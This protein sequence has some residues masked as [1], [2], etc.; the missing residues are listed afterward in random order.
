MER[1]SFSD[2]S[3]A[4]LMNHAFV[5]IKVDREERP[6]VDGIYMKAVQALTGQGGW[7]LTAFLTPEGKPFFGGTYF[8][9]QPRH[10]M[11]AFSQVL[12]AVVEA[13]RNRRED[14]LRNAGHLLA[15]IEKSAV[16]VEPGS[17]AF[18][19]GSSPGRDLAAHAYRHLASR[20]DNEHGGFGGAPKFPQPV[21]LEFLLG[22]GVASGE[23]QAVEMVVE[24]LRSMAR[25][26]IR[27]H[28]AGGFHRYSVDERWV[29]PHFEKMLYDNALLARVYL[30]AY[31]VTGDVALRE[32]CEETLGYVLS[33][34]ADPSGGFYAARDADSEGEEGRFYLWTAEEIQAAAKDCA[35]EAIRLSL[36]LY[37]VSRGGNFEG[38]NILHQPLD[39]QRVAE[40]EGL[41]V[42]DL[43]DRI[44]PVRR[45]LLAER[46]RRVPPF[47]DEKVVCSWSA[48]AVRAFAEAGIALERDD[49][50][51][52][53]VA[54]GRFLLSEMVSPEG[55]L[56]TWKEGVAKIPAFLEDWGALGNA[57]LSLHEATLDPVWLA[58]AQWLGDEILARFSGQEDGLLYDAPATGGTLVTRP[59]DPVDNAIPSGTSLAAE[60][61]LRG[62]ALLGTAEWTRAAHAILAREAGAM[63][64]FPGGFGR[65][66]A[67]VV[68]ATTPSVEVAVLG[69]PE[70][71]RTRALLARVHREWH[72]NRTVA[73]GDPDRESLPEIP[74]FRGRG[75]VDGV[76]AAWVCR[77]FACEAPVTSADALESLLRGLD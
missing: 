2:P 15:A 16:A 38:R 20:F 40:A 63:E 67:Q 3:T 8:P 7:P 32:V 54:G 68:R 28:L 11:P 34:L 74:L 17:G 43:R 48:F 60:L 62:G 50:R 45:A 71:S 19:G 27:D 75:T 4:E 13:W 64:R 56:R 35:P 44:A 33:D 76:P 49:F 12:G 36:R 65:L 41:S 31:R 30:D 10:G 14:V 52:A 77:N 24:T 66:L 69:D 53:A 57:C 21:T 18:S 37:D 70:D 58:H 42:S 55:L 46:A 59:R 5:N 39:E 61:F 25:G 47:R 26:G 72:P 51:D 22:H 9:P 6:D 23:L 1:E 73:G 29:V